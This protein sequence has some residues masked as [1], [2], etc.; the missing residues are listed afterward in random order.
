MEFGSGVSLLTDSEAAFDEALARALSGFVNAPD[1]LV[2]FATPHHTEYWKQIAARLSMATSISGTSVGAISEGVTCG[3]E[4]FETGPALTVWAGW[5]DGGMATAMRL[6]GFRTDEGIGISG[7][8]VPEACQGVILIADPYSFPVG[9]VADSLTPVPV[10]GGL[11]ATSEDIQMALNGVVYDSGAVAIALH[12][13]LAVRAGV[14][15]GG[16]PIGFP[17]TV[18]KATGRSIEE[19]GGE[20]AFAYVDSLINSLDEQRRRMVS[21]GLQLGIA[22][23]ERDLDNG[24]GEFLLRSVTGV[25]REAGSIVISDIVPV[26]STVQF[27]LRDRAAS[28]QDLREELA[29]FADGGVLMFTCNARGVEFFDQPHHDAGMVDALVQPPASAGLIGVGEVGPVGGRSNVHGYST[30]IIQIGS[31][32]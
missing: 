32:V 16:D 3:S 10:V 22:L 24:Q 11:P 17:L 7:L 26:G 29:H 18:T 4:E 14:S 6:V 1:L 9:Q 31:P 2:C 5:F 12:G 21:D 25:D 19:F 23:N 30:A 8:E 28:E 13:P 20:P 15:Q 27:H